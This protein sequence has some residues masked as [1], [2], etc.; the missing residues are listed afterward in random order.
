MNSPILDMPDEKTS[1]EGMA[2]DPQDGPGV[3]NGSTSTTC[4]GGETL[5]STAMDGPDM[6]PVT[7]EKQQVRDAWMLHEGMKIPVHRSIVHEGNDRCEQ[8]SEF[9]SHVAASMIKDDASLR[10]VI[11]GRLDAVGQV[12]EIRRQLGILEKAPKHGAMIYHQPLVRG[13]S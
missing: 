13:D 5:V 7:E 6:D 3:D 10:A 4:Q 9:V 12:T 11:E 2:I 1:A 8:C